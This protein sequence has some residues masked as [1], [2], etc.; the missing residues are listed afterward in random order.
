[1]KESSI[2]KNVFVSGGTSG[3]GLCCVENFL[4]KGF[5]VAFCARTSADVKSTLDRLK[6]LRLSKSKVLGFTADVSDLE[7]VNF[8]KKKLEA[9]NFYVDILICNAGVI[10]AIEKF[11]RQNQSE[12]RK[13]FEVNMFGTS[14]LVFSFLPSMLQE[15]WGRI[16]HLSGGGATAPIEGMS[17]YAASK[18]ASVRFIETLAREYLDS[19]V[20]LNS[21]SPGFMK[22]RLLSQMIQAGSDR[23]GESLYIKSLQ[24]LR[25]NYDSY[26]KPM[27]LIEF[28]IQDKA[29]LITGKLIS[30]EWDNWESWVAHSEELMSSDLYTLR[31][32]TGRDRGVVWGD[33]A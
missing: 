28:L 17:S 32:I 15:G 12:W 33:L 10:G 20:T 29:G 30:A 25:D 22:T 5:N 19:G 21:I 31:R 4:A 7:Q 9:D 1:M 8:I 26:L 16:L 13:S 14:N 23:I 27:K 18:A 24:K 11:D 6:S 2:P 3:L